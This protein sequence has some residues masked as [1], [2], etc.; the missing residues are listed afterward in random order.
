[1]TADGY[2]HAQRVVA[3]GCKQ[4]PSYRADLPLL[5][6]ESP[7][8]VAGWLREHVR[9]ARTRL[10]LVFDDVWTDANRETAQ[11]IYDAAFDHVNA[12]R[13]GEQT[14]R[15]KARE[16]ACNFAANLKRA[17]QTVDVD[18][19]GLPC[20]IVGGGPSL[21]GSINA[22]RSFRGLIIAVNTALPALAHHGIRP[23]LGISIESI[24]TPHT[25][26]DADFPMLLA[27]TAAQENWR[28]ARHPCAIADDEPCTM[29][30]ALALG[31]CPLTQGGS[32]TTVAIAYAAQI[33]CSEVVLVGQDH[34]Y[35][36]ERAYARHT[37]FPDIGVTQADGALHFSGTTK[38][39]PP[40]EMMM[41][42]AWGGGTV[43]TT[44]V[45]AMY[46]DY[47]ARVAA[48]M[49]IVNTSFMGAR[50]DGTIEQ[51]LDA[52]VGAQ[53]DT[54]E[55]AIAYRR[56]STSS[57]VWQLQSDLV[58]ASRALKAGDAHGA[59]MACLPLN[60]YELVHILDREPRR[61][62]EESDADTCAALRDGACE[63]LQAM[64]SA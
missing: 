42:P 61:L 1:M 36:Q 26:V 38:R 10:S 50:I 40:G 29:P 37:A 21:D 6:S 25:V 24:P 59:T 28:A 33:G 31:L 63:L 30:Y 4:L 18:A 53:G 43:P 49:R 12:A 64:G 22:L 27:L 13:I 58:R 60:M 32:T 8:E 16:H 17:T 46:R 5:R 34:A 15:L 23:H 2:Q 14:T 20:A 54:G 39:M 11:A 19:R 35:P 47:I 7:A 62:R 45:M 44:R 48:R 56:L 3:V 9:N 55:P 57:A 52:Y 41:V 51:R